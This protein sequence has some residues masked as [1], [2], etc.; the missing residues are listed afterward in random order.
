M[1]VLIIAG[2]D[3]KESTTQI[4]EK[5]AD[6]MKG[7]IIKYGVSDDK[8]E[9]VKGVSSI[10]E[11]IKLLEKMK[12]FKIIVY[13]AH[14]TEDNVGIINRKNVNKFSTYNNSKAEM[15]LIFCNAGKG[16]NPIAQEIANNLGITVIA[17]ND[18]VI[19]WLPDNKN[20]GT[21]AISSSII[22]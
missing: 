3:K 18:L 12:N 21:W 13:H 5:G 2:F 7:D 6:V 17:A 8:I 22:L 20:I 11:I 19:T 14:G 15:F 1:E 10:S 9:V 16:E 4:I